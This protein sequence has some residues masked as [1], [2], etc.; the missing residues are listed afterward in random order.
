[1]NGEWLQ[2][3]CYAFSDMTQPSLFTI[4]Y[5]PFTAFTI[6]S[7]SKSCSIRLRKAASGRGP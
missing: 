6:H 3:S 5:L 7:L 2:N 1:M 4:H